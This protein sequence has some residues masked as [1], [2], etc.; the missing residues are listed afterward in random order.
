MGS[1][2]VFTALRFYDA[3]KYILETNHAIVSVLTVI[4]KSWYDKLPADLQK[5][6]SDAGQKASTEVYQ[7]SFDFVEFQRQAWIK[8]GGELIQQTPAEH[9]QL[10]KLMLPIGAEVTSK[11]PEEKAL[12][13]LLQKAAKR[14]E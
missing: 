9:A 8:A 11:K 14:T 10:M 4:S 7:W 1:T 12:Y 6:V 5:V 3:A 13:E 2:P